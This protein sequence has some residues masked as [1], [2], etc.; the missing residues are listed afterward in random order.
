MNVVVAAALGI[1]NATKDLVIYPLYI[2]GAFVDY[3]QLTALTFT[4]CSAILFMV[5]L[6]LLVAGWKLKRS[7]KE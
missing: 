2:A 3:F 4:S 7:E 6:V 1:V 5:F